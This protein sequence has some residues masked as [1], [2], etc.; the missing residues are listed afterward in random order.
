MESVEL[1]VGMVALYFCNGKAGSVCEFSTAYSTDEFLPTVTFD[2]K[3]TDTKDVDFTS[4]A[5]ES[6]GAFQ[7]MK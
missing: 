5:S 1:F 2:V 4:S 3:A 6:I 7:D